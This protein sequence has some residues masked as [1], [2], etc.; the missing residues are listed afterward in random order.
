MWYIPLF[1]IFVFYF[2]GCF[3]PAGSAAARTRIPGWAKYLLLPLN[4]AYYWYL[5]TEGQIFPLFF[6]TT[7]AM[8]AVWVARRASGYQ[9]DA[10]GAFLLVSFLASI[11][12]VGIWSWWLWDDA[13]LRQKYTSVIYVPEPWSWMTLYHREMISH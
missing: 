1:G 10:N 6:C 7:A 2:D 3:A 12:L 4:A 9:V 5:A 13:T 8:V 11:V